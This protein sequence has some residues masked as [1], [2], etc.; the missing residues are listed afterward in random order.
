MESAGQRQNVPNIKNGL[1]KFFPQGFVAN[2]TET[3]RISHLMEQ[4]LNLITDK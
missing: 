2:R 4:A 3:Y 1:C